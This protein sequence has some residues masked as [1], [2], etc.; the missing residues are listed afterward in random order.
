MSELGYN[1]K[2]YRSAKRMSQS[3][4][5]KKLEV[6][7]GMISQWEKGIRTPRF[8]TLLRLAEA[9]D[10][11]TEL[12]D[13]CDEASIEHYLF[14]EPLRDYLKNL[15]YVIELSKESDPKRE[16]SEIHLL[17]IPDSHTFRLVE[18]GT[19][20]TAYLS[21]DEL[22]KLEKDINDYIN[23]KMQQ[24]K[25]DHPNDPPLEDVL[26]DRVIDLKKEFPP[27]DDE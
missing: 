9:L 17:E 27:L 10:V 4:L 16:G 8:A 1:I 23:F 15:N 2:M 24:L 26:I 7:Q 11:P 25:A 18:G 19:A 20:F 5:A 14:H 3:D 12:L 6:T 13:P 22:D 21:R